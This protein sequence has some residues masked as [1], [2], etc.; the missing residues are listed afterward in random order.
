MSNSMK[1]IVIFI[2]STKYKGHEHVLILKQYKTVWLFIDPFATG[3]LEIKVIDVSLAVWLMKLGRY[4]ELDF[5]N[6]YQPFKLGKLLCLSCV[7]FVKLYFGITEKSI[8][9]SN[10]LYDYLTGKPISFK[11]RLLMPFI[12]IYYYLK[13]NKNIKIRKK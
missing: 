12:F 13:F 7:S 10:Q 4:I 5:N 11:Q 8:L 9:T 6:A 3:N 1:H 2:P